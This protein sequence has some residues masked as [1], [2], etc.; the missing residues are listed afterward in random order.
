[1]QRLP[2]RYFQQ[3]KVG[4]VISKILSD[5]DQTKTL[6]TELVT[7]TTQN[8]AQIVA[9][10]GEHQRTSCVLLFPA[11]EERYEPVTS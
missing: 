4:Q 9:T 7:R 2:L 3:T 8:I 10:E 6:V 5:T 1:M 11:R